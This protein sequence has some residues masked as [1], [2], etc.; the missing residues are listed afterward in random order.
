M[1]KTLYI[2]CLIIS[3]TSSISC[4][5][6][7][8]MN[9]QYPLPSGYE[10]VGYKSQ[11]RMTSIEQKYRKSARMTLEEEN[12]LLRISEDAEKPKI[13]NEAKELL[14]QRHI[15]HESDKEWR[16]TLAK[17]V[18]MFKEKRNWTNEELKYTQEIAANPNHELHNKAIL[19]LRRKMIN[20]ATNKGV[21]RTLLNERIGY[22]ITDLYKE[23][24]P[25]S[26]EE[27]QKLRAIAQDDKD[28]NSDDAKKLLNIYKDC[29]GY[30]DQNIGSLLQNEKSN[31]K[32][33]QHDQQEEANDIQGIQEFL[34]S[35]KI[36][37]ILALLK[38]L[39][40]F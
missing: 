4:N 38:E 36:Q 25:Y 19:V 10:H 11:R 26:L 16:Q 35:V 31:V 33:L 1:K 8:S 6:S 39:E 40:G 23:D 21:K 28:R 30:D 37:E 22:P 14:F 2:I 18:A 5:A 34:A 13:Q 29:F 27:L 20:N 9:L 12:E 32:S 15:K 24:H 7:K 3:C 17:T